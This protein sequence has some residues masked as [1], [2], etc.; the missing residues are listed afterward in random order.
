MRVSEYFKLGRGQ[1]TL[2]FVDVDV[3]GDARVFVDPRALR[4]LPSTWGDEC[5]SLVQDFFTEVLSAI[6]SHEDARARQLL[7]TLREPNETHLGFSRGRARGRALGRDSARDV[8][9]ALSKSDA[10]SSGLLEDLEDT[11]LMVEGISSDIISDITTNI[12]RQPLI[13][14][15]QSVASL[16]GIPL[17]ADVSSGPMWDPKRGEWFTEYVAL[18][19]TRWGKLLL[20]PKI[21][22]R[23]RMDYDVQEYYRHY[24]LEHLKEAELDANSELVYLLKDGRRRVNKKDLTKKYGHGKATIV[25]E[26]RKH[27]EILQRYRDDKRRHYRP[28]LD[29]E[30][31]AESEGTPGPD[32]DRLLRDL[33]DTR[34]GTQAFAQYEKAIE[35]LLSA[36]FYPSLANP[37]LQREIH[38]GR[39]RVDLVYTNAAASGFFGW[40]GQHYSAPHV[41]IEC[42]NY[43]G[44]PGNP[45]LDQLSGRFSP[46]RGQLGILTCRGFANK[47][48]FLRRCRDTAADHRGFILVLDDDDLGL[49]VLER[50]STGLAPVYALLKRQFEDLIM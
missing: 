25:R 18:P 7:R 31:L 11:I 9:A 37:Q 12:I 14:Y 16:Y 32:W 5:V 8:W 38:E 50:K 41:F 27:P 4:V 33:L 15:T 19:R 26:T 2:D 1:P 43:V 3:V 44:D 28:P 48:R 23:T 47:K 34:P 17:E 24:L 30:A 40:V 39:K 49:L 29:H 21:I 20:V 35:S 46:S 45:E 6:R 42:K 36:L 10:V 22:V 13:E